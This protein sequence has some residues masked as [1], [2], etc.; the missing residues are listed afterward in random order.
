MSRADFEDKLEKEK[1]LKINKHGETNLH[2]AARSGNLA[3]LKK[4]VD[5]V[6]ILNKLN[7]IVLLVSL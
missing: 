3:L 7:H 5:E 2:L 4:L 6:N 1:D